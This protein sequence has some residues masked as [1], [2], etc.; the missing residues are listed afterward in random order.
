MHPAEFA[1]L[2]LVVYLAHWLTRKGTRAGSLLH[3]LLPFLLITG[4]LLLLVVLEPDLGTTGV[5]TLIAFVMFFVAGASIWQLALLAPLGV[6]AVAW[7]CPSS[8]YQMERV[9]AFLNPWTDPQG[10]GFHTRPGPARDWAWA[11]R[12]GIGLGE[13][14]QPG[15]LQLP[16]AAQRLRLRRSSARSSASSAAWR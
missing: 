9:Q 3:G 10:N 12:S 5:L 1:K 14:R 7:P 15:A 16:N 6:A 4:P 2:A 13:S 11:G 8:E